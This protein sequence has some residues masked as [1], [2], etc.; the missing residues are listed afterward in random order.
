MNQDKYDKL[1]VSLEGSLGSGAGI[2]SGSDSILPDGSS[3]TNIGDT[4]NGGEILPTQAAPTVTEAPPEATKIPEEDIVTPVAS[5]GTQSTGDIEGGI[6][7][8]K[9]MANLETHV[10]NIL[11]DMGMDVSAGTSLKERGLT[12]SFTND[13]FFDS[14][15][16]ILKEDMKKG[17]SKLV[18][19]LNNIDNSIIIEGHTDNVPISKTSKYSSNW[20][21]SAGRAANVAEYLVDEEKVDGA[22][23]AA[24]GYGEYRPKVSN[25]IKKGQSV[26]RRID[27][28]IL[29]DNEKG[30]EYK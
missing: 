20:Q 23:V 9:D 22:R 1:S 21:L 15:Q 10:N 4:G 7:S 14:G 3:G 18:K 2:F 19:L 26:N 16:D 11:V 30:I 13:I 28:I 29:Y 27:I 25:D 24:V 8:E 5:E 17:L 6:T 12:I